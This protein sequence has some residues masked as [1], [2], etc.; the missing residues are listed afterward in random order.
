V[1]GKKGFI[2]T[3]FVD[4]AKGLSVVLV[5][6]YLQFTDVYTLLCGIA[7]LGGHIWPLQLKFK[8]GKGISVMVGFFFVWN[9]P[10]LFITALLG[11]IVFL[12]IRRFTMSGLA[13][14]LVVPL[15]SV[16]MHLDIRVAGLL[17]LMIGIIY[18]AHR[19][20]IR[21][22]FTINFKTK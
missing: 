10:V 4:F 1:L 13:G 18:F 2:I 21:E 8:G 17:W 19:D 9:F 11:L 14:L 7:L 6:K 3:F 16:F 5:C 20:N 12:F 15:Y 22:Y